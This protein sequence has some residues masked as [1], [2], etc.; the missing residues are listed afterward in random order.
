M[1]TILSFSSPEKR[2]RNLL[3]SREPLPL[4]LIFIIAFCFQLD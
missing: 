2:I 4:I 3:I 1:K